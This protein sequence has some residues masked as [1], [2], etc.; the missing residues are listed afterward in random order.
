MVEPVGA[1]TVLTVVG[2]CVVPV[3][4]VVVPLAVA[5]AEA[6]D[7]HFA[8]EYAMGVFES[9]QLVDMVV[10]T[11]D[12]SAGSFAPRQDAAD[13]RNPPPLLQTQALNL[14]TVEWSQAEESA[15]EYRQDCEFL[16]YKEKSNASAATL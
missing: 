9:P 7:A 3:L 2:T 16:G 15:A 6:T 12:T 10:Y 8:D 14:G 11:P 13:S 4:A 1:V 5:F